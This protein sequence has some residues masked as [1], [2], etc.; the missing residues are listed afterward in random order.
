MGFWLLD[1]LDESE[2][3]KPAQ[4]EKALRNGDFATKVFD[5]AT[6]DETY[7]LVPL[8]S[9][10][11]TVLAAH[12][13]DLSGSL[14]CMAFDCLRRDLDRL[15]SRT[16]F[17]FDQVAVRGPSKQVVSHLVDGASIDEAKHNVES[18][19]RG[20]L[21][22]REVGAEEFLVFTE[23]A[24]AC[25]VHYRQHLSEAGL[26]HI[27]SNSESI[28]AELMQNGTVADFEPHGD[29]LH[30]TFTHPMLEHT[31]W[32]CLDVHADVSDPE[33][34]KRAAAEGVFVRFAS[35]LTSDVVTA[36]ML[37]TPLGL[38]TGVHDRLVAD[39]LSD[40]NVALALDLPILTDVPPKDAMKIRAAEG[41]SFDRFRDALRAGMNDAVAA[42]GDSPSSGVAADIIN[43]VI[44][45][46]L[47]EVDDAMVKSQNLLNKKVATSVGLGTVLTIA[48]LAFNAPLLLPAGIAIFG[49]T[50]LQAVHKYFEES[51]DIQLKDMYFLWSR[52]VQARYRK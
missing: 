10:G 12:G 50:T 48:G 22:I 30:C 26:D 14:D 46:S 27:L 38:G 3:R 31:E 20:L 52:E 47:R 11:N 1:L 7:S 24:P 29:H 43:D 49:G 25:R 23:K 44:G 32:P 33:V 51:R 17:Y 40:E 15:L 6:A 8:E 35:H 45:P 16:W 5:V 39:H 36:Q 18:L 4:L 19:M 41:G 13:L 37:G 2:I 34:I 28:V 42:S 9:A 21:Y